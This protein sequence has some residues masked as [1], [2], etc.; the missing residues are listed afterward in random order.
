[1]PN[2][3]FNVDEPF[4]QRLG[5][6]PGAMLRLLL[7]ASVLWLAAAVVLVFILDVPDFGTWRFWLL[8]VS[9]F[10]APWLAGAAVFAVAAMGIGA[11]RGLHRALRPEL[12]A[13]RSVVP[14][15]N[16]PGH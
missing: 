1:M 8:F 13:L 12:A 11:I 16:R 9:Y 15:R 2:T 10:V 4:A 7:V 5:S 6:D 14:R 3:L